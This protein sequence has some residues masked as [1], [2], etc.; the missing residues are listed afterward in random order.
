MA[1]IDD[2]FEGYNAAPLNHSAL[3]RGV[4]TSAG[5]ALGGAKGV[6]AGLGVWTLGVGATVGVITFLATGGLVA[7]LVVGSLAAIGSVVFGG[8]LAAAV[9]GI[10]GL[11]GGASRE[12]TRV[13][14]DQSLYN[15]QVAEALGRGAAQAQN[16]APARPLPQPVVVTQPTMREE[17]PMRRDDTVALDATNSTQPST[18]TEMGSPIQYDGTINAQ[19][20]LARL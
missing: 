17:T 4:R 11:V 5:A 9:G 12:N 2:R 19:R 3:D 16:Y 1:R 10:V 7:P 6:A 14:L 15:I 20:A 18:K 13:T 8:P